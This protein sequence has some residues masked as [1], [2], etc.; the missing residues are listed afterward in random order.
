[1]AAPSFFPL[2]TDARPPGGITLLGFMGFFT[3]LLAGY[4]PRNHHFADSSSCL[5]L[6]KQEACQ[7]N[8]YLNYY[9]FSASYL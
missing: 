9:L 2:Y 1:M 3:R 6:Y 8:G 4:I 5:T 7:K